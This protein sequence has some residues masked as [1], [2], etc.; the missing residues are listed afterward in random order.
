MHGA[1]N[2]CQLLKL[3]CSQV[4]AEK[5]SVNNSLKYCSAVCKQNR[6]AILEKKNKQKQ[7]TA[8]TTQLYIKQLMII[9]IFTVRPLKIRFLKFSSNFAQWHIIGSSSVNWLHWIPL[10]IVIAVAETKHSSSLYEVQQP[11]LTWNKQSSFFNL[12]SQSYL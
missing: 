6:L 12:E 5:N 11:P 2:P 1:H 9:V 7:P 3:N 10:L 4:S 8:K